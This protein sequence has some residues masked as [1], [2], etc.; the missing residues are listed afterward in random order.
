MVKTL[1]ELGLNFDSVRELRRKSRVAL[2]RRSQLDGFYSLSF[3]S[4]ILLS[5]V[6]EE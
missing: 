2:L 4:F 5:P 6:S 1:T 3:P